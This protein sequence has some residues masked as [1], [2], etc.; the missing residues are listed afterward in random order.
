MPV[1]MRHHES[2]GERKRKYAGNVRVYNREYEF[3]V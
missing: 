3:Y 2:A 1:W